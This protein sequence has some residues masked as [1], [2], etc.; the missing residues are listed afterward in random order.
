MTAIAIPELPPS[1]IVIQ[2]G[3]VVRLEIWTLWNL[4]PD[5]TTL[6]QRREKG[7][8]CYRGDPEH[9]GQIDEG[10]AENLLT[11]FHPK[12]GAEYQQLFALEGAD[13]KAVR[14]LKGFRGYKIEVIPAPKPDATWTGAE[15]CDQGVNV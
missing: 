3:Q 11:W 4:M 8:S 10:P 9:G 5:I 15:S 1:R 2:G 7:F 12:I 13:E 14:K 6:I